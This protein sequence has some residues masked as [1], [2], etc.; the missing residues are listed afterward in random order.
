MKRLID[1]RNVGMVKSMLTIAQ[2]RPQETLF[3][4][5]G[6]GHYPG[7]K[8][9]L[10]LLRKTGYRVRQLKTL[11][12]LEKPWPLAAPAAAVSPGSRRAPRKRRTIRVGPFCIP[13]PCCR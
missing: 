8:G 10:A 11:A 7:P 12:D 4:A 2:E 1:D 9:I 3:V 6:T 5:V 13:L